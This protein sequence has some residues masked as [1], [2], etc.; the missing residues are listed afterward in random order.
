MEHWC[1]VLSLLRM[2]FYSVSCCY[3]TLL[4]AT[5][6]RLAD[7]MT[8]LDDRPEMFSWATRVPNILGPWAHAAHASATSVSRVEYGGVCTWLHISVGEVLCFIASPQNKRKGVGEL[9]KAGLTNGG[10][11]DEE[12]LLWSCLHVR[13]GNDLCVLDSF[14]FI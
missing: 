6:S 4:I 1:G 2:L 5:P 12:N 14:H 7:G 10:V 3:L 13:A 9:F 11:V 8:V